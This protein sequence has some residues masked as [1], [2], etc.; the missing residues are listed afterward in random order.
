MPFASTSIVSSSSTD[1]SS[2]NIHSD[3]SV[4]QPQVKLTNHVTL[5][6]TLYLHQLLL[7]T[8]GTEHYVWKDYVSLHITYNVTYLR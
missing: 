7:S 8:Q 3:S 2:R 5:H 6:V 1:Y 4:F